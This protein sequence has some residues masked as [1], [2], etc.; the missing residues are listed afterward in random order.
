MDVFCGALR[1]L[2]RSVTAMVISLCGACGLRILWIAT[3][4][5][6]FTTPESVYFSYP[7][8]WTLTAACHLI[9]V[10]IAAKKLMREDREQREFNECS[11]NLT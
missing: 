5:Q 1:A 4:F 7:V 2:D 10:I 6:V 3:I 8:S 9:F 11:K